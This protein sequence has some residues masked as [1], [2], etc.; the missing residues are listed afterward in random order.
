MLPFNFAVVV[1]LRSPLSVV[2]D[3]QADRLPDSKPS[4]KIGSG[5]GGIVAV[6]VDVN[7][8]VKVGVGVFVDVRVGV[9]VGVV[10]GV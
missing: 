8:G 5:G 9:Q 1:T 10:V 7:V 6:G 4:A 3:D 2:E